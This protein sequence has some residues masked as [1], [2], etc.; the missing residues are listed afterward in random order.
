MTAEHDPPYTDAAACHPEYTLIDRGNRLL[1][2]PAC[3][4]TY[5]RHATP[6]ERRRAR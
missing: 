2:C 5:W 4:Q 1:E 6:E 3:G